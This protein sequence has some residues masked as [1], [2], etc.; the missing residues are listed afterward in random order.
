M[1]TRDDWKK[2]IDRLMAIVGVSSTGGKLYTAISEYHGNPRNKAL[3]LALTCGGCA[4]GIYFGVSRL[5][6]DHL[7]KESTPPAAKC[8]HCGHTGD[9]DYVGVHS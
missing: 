5:S 9:H 2:A 3:N 7:K 6:S 8:P 1:V 4:S